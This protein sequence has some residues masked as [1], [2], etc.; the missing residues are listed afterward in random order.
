M[1]EESGKVSE[2]GRENREP[3]ISNNNAKE[4]LEKE[5]EEK[6]NLRGVSHPPSI[7]SSHFSR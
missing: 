5:E 7:N 3:T 2:D 1:D 4:G 6:C